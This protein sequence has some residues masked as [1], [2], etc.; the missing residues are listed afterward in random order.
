MRRRG[1]IAALDGVS[2][3]QSSG[4]ADATGGALASINSSA[5]LNALPPGAWR[6]RPVRATVAP[7]P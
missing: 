4:S 1:F 2:A 5:F 7:N 6:A 3:A